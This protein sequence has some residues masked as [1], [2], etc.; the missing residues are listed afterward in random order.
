MAAHLTSYRP[1][2][3]ST[4]AQHTTTRA[5]SH[6]RKVCHCLRPRVT[7][8]CWSRHASRS[9]SP[10]ISSA[11]SLRPH[12]WIALTTSRRR[13]SMVHQS[14][15]PRHHVT[16]IH[17]GDEHKQSPHLYLTSQISHDTCTCG[18]MRT[19]AITSHIIS[20]ECAC[21]NHLAIRTT[22]VLPPVSPPKP[23][24]AIVPPRTQS[25]RP[26]RPS[27]QLATAPPPTC[28][29]PLRS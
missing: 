16:T 7:S 23:G 28:D 1:S 14:Q 2:P 29:L 5:Q 6:R 8:L 3:D 9:A 12:V 13:A 18:C 26:R 24:G 15:P 27:R 19:A 22:S 20:G 10:S 17:H 11:P 25:V 4:A 21:T